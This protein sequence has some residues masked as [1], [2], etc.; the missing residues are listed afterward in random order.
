MDERKARIVFEMVDTED[1]DD[2]LSTERRT[3]FLSILSVCPRS[4]ETAAGLAIGEITA[5]ANCH[6]H[7]DHSGQN[8]LFPGVPIFVQPAEWAAAHGPEEYTINDWID[9]PGARYEQIPGDWFLLPPSHEKD[10][11]AVRDAERALREY[12]ERYPSDENIPQAT[13]VQG[14][15]RMNLDK[16]AGTDPGD[17]VQLGTID[18]GLSGCPAI[19]TYAVASTSDLRQSVD[20]ITDANGGFWIFLGTQSS[21]DGRHELWLSQLK[22]RFVIP[23]P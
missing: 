18:N 2:R 16:G 6:L 8:L 12:V 17:Y 13:D 14:T 11:A 10:Q 4:H 21:Y 20:L 9:F 19:G 23:T 7:A 15:Y 1:A 5:V 22:L 3:I